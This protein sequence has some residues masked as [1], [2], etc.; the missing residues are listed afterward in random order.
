LRF[1]FEG[2]AMELAKPAPLGWDY[3]SVAAVA[4]T[5]ALKTG[6]R[7]LADFEPLLLG[8]G[9]RAERVPPS[10]WARPDALAARVDGPKNFV[11]FL[12]QAASG[13]DR[14]FFATTLG[15]YLLHSKEGREPM[16]FARFAKGQW[17]LEGLWFGMALTVPD[18]EFA[19]AQAE[20]VEDAQLAAKLW[21]PPELLALKRRLTVQAA[22]AAS[23][24]PSS[25]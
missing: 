14:L 12:P 8:M 23:R 24:S 9:G 22:K 16:E 11:A 5:I 20:G 18:I 10:I 19:Q 25:F 2:V 15:H 4:D 7:S 3:A 6:L 1:I 13:F 17:S 21:V